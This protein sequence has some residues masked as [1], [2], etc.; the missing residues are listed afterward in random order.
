MER[1]DRHAT[2]SARDGQREAGTQLF[3]YQVL[4]DALARDDEAFSYAPWKSRPGIL[5][6]KARHTLEAALALR[7]TGSLLMENRERLGHTLRVL[8]PQSIVDVPG[9]ELYLA[10]I[11]GPGVAEGEIRSLLARKG[12]AAVR[13]RG[14][15]MFALGA[16]RMERGD[17][18]GALEALAAADPLLPAEYAVFRTQLLALKARAQTARGDY[19]GALESLVGVMERDG[20]EIRRMGLRLPCR[21]EASPGALADQAARLLGSSPRLAPGTGGFRVVVEQAATGGLVGGL[22]GPRGAV[23]SRFHVPP[24][25][26]A[27]ATVREFCRQFHRR[28]FGPKIDLSQ[29]QIRSLEGSTLSSQGAEEHLKGIMGP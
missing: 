22:D 13:E 14:F 12:P 17:A 19:A 5:L 28:A 27:D 2:G 24:G 11:V 23:L 10:R 21:I 1:P 20:G 29:Q 3:H 8:A 16:A 4:Q 26:D 7:R 9:G 25:K 6:R 18:R 15:L